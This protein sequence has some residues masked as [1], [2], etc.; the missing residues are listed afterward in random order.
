MCPHAATYKPSVT[1]GTKLDQNIMANGCTDAIN[2]ILKY[3]IEK[4]VVTKSVL[5]LKGHS[6]SAEHVKTYARKKCN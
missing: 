5:E 2:F 1:N 4:F 6:V 3:F